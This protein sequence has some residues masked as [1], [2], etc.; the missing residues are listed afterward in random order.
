M[1]KFLAATEIIDRSHPA[2][3]DLAQNI[4]SKNATLRAI[5]NKFG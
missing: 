3:V 4:A 2:I 5:A 1:E